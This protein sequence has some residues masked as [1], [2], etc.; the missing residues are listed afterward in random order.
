MD[1]STLS[2]I[3]LIEKLHLSGQQP[4]SALL[5]TVIDKKSEVG[6]QLIS[7]LRTVLG[8]DLNGLEV[9]D[10]RRFEGMLIGRLCIEMELMGALP[11]LAELMRT[12]W[13][14]DVTIDGLD[15][16]LAHFGPDAVPVL[17]ALV[18]MN[19]LNKWHNGK[20]IAIT[21]LTDIALLFPQSSSA[22]KSALR[23]TLP[24]LNAN[25]G[26]SAPKDEM[27]GEVAIALAKLQDQESNKRILA[28]IRQ[29]VTDSAV[30]T[31]DRYESFHSGK[32]TARM[33][34]P[35]SIM[36]KYAST[37]AFEEM[38]SNLNVADG[39][40]KADP[41]FDMVAAAKRAEAKRLAAKKSVGR[42][43]PCPCGSGKKHKA[44]CGKK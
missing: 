38:I 8:T 41:A 5:Q 17:G 19:T 39:L 18:E 2:P 40:E 23:S 22:V 42:N 33:P 34:E 27:W 37:Q 31:R 3:E 29:G 10:P 13:S 9:N 6:A 25:G 44:C 21:T 16:D 30:I 35:F 15:R 20:S 43:D 7:R 11:I 14:E 28:M 26:I 1:Y 32:K 24:Q 4:E 36:T 12:T